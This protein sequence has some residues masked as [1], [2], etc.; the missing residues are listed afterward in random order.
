[1]SNLFSADWMS[2]FKDEWNKEPELGEALSKIGFDS[3][4]GYGFIDDDTAKGFIKIE[5]GMVVNAGAYTGEE[6]NWDLRASDSQWNSWMEKGPG[7]TG[8]GLAFT[9]GKLKFNKGD[10]GAMV[11]D[12]RMANPFMKSFAVMGRIS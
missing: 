6:L 2:K 5:N 1:M 9:T 10:Y 11:K 8:L 4:I 7:M 12:P 3:V